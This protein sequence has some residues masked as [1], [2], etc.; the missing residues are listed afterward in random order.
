MALFKEQSDEKPNLE[1][2]HEVCLQGRQLLAV[3]LLA[4]V[5]PLISIFVS[6]WHD[7]FRDTA[8]PLDS[9]KCPPFCKP[10]VYRALCTVQWQLLPI[11]VEDV[12]ASKPF[13]A[14]HH[15]RRLPFIDQECIGRGGY[16]NVYKVIIAESYTS[17]SRKGL[18]PG[19][20]SVTYS[21]CFQ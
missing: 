15:N 12:E 20:V 5:K 7:C 13:P 8:L 16:G 11:I 18:N 6:L 17:H 3:C 2:V 19:S 10:G 9:S 1:F 14:Y 4:N 21:L